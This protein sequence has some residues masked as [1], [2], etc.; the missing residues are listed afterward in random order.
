[1]ANV[2]VNATVGMDLFD[3]AAQ[4]YGDIT[5][6]TLIARANGLTDPIIQTDQILTIP[7]YSAAEANDGILASQ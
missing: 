2:T 3:L 7:A 6:W 5:A 4:L 1:M